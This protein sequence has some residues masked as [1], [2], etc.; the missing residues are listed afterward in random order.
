[1]RTA[2]EPDLLTENL[3]PRAARGAPGK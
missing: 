3:S 1:V 2:G